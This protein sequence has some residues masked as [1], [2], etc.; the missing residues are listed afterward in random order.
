MGVRRSQGKRGEGREEL[1][2]FGRVK[3]AGEAGFER[4]G[5]WFQEACSHWKSSRRS[6]DASFDL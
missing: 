3:E 1:I 5:S 6:K 2:C 4:F